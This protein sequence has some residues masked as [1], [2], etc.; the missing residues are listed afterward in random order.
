MASSQWHKFYSATVGAPAA[1]VFEVLSDLPN[2]GRWLPGSA[3]FRQ[4]TDV[5]PY[6][7][8]LGS[9]YH[10]GKPGETGKD[11]WGTVI[12]FQPP[13]SLDFHHTIRVSQLRATVDVHIHYSFEAQAGST[14]VTR[15][16]V[17]DVT[18]PVVFRPLRRLIVTSFDRENV[19]TMTAAKVYAETHSN[20]LPPLERH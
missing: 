17:L 14:Q 6:P 8:Q 15:W 13:G 18:M 19:R 5:E 3:Q 1:I 12:G 4:T 9:R 2:Y 20:G 11:W 16:L 7:V 10:D